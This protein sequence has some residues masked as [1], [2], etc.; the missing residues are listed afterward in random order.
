MQVPTHQTWY[1]TRHSFIGRDG[2][3]GP[4]QLQTMESKYV[5]LP[6]MGPFH[7]QLRCCGLNCCCYT[8]QSILSVPQWL[9]LRQSW[10]K[11]E[12]GSS[13]M[14]SLT[15]MKSSSHLYPGNSRWYLII[16][17]SPIKDS[18]P[19]LFLIFYVCVSAWCDLLN[20]LVDAAFITLTFVNLLHALEGQN[21]TMAERVP[22]PPPSK[23]HICV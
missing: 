8:P 12:Q 14:E 20:M 10:W 13:L 3:P 17:N 4:L 22:L 18:I 15:Q 6:S 9:T 16:N 2:G 5:S 1:C 11:L 19:L 23:L 7:A 21:S